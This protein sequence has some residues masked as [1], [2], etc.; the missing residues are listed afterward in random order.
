MLLTEFHARLQGLLALNA[1]SKGAG[2]AAELT[3]YGDEVV[4]VGDRLAAPAAD[5][6]KSWG[7]LMRCIGSLVRWR[8]AV[9]DAEIDG[10]RHLRAARQRAQNVLSTL[11]DASS[12]SAEIRAAAER[13]VAVVD[14][15]AIPAAISAVAAVPLP[16]PFIAEQRPPV[17]PDPRLPERPG[18]LKALAFVQFDISGRPVNE[19][20]DVRA[21]LVYDLR[22][23]V[24]LSAPIPADIELTPYVVEPEGIVEAPSFTLRAGSEIRSDVGRLLVRIAH[25][26]LARPLEVAYGL[27]TLGAREDLAIE[28]R[29]QGQSRLVLRCVEDTYTWSGNEAIE[30][31]VIDARAKARSNGLHDSN[32]APFLK[33]FGSTA[34]IAADA[35]ASSVFRGDWPE[36]KFHSE[37]RRRLRQDRD[38]GSDLE[39]HAHA[40]GG[41]TDLSFQRVRLELKCDDRPLGVEEA[42]EAYGQQLIQYV[43][44]SDRRTGVLAVLCPV[45]VGAAP[46]LLHNDLACV[47]VPPPT[48]GNRAV[49][50]AVALVRSN[51][52]TPSSRSRRSDQPGASGHRRRRARKP[53]SVED[54]RSQD[55]AG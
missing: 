15:A 35:L 26:A 38:I 39:D 51:L 20:Q 33:L 11:A 6:Y 25:D 43:V 50:I 42:F 54:R 12:A 21:N 31:A 45:K 19:V 7:E 48:G 2:G 29:G 5:A 44:G 23:Q 49:L 16:L 8:A 41:I 14:P 18:P 27:K 24:R 9:L 55:L 22:V 34:H 53:G 10:D 47:V 13:V 52:P 4:R 36:E 28:L 37:V 1:L 32:T 3:A 17:H 40:S 46:G 30:E